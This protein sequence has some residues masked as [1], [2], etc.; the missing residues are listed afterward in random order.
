MGLGIGVTS[1]L[2]KGK[3]EAAVFK[4]IAKA[5]PGAVTDEVMKEVCAV[6]VGEEGVFA[7]LFPQCE[8]LEFVVHEGKLLASTKTSSCGP[9][10]HAEVVDVLNRIGK[11]CGLRWE[12]DGEHGGDETGFAASG[13]FDDLQGQMARDIQ[14]IAAHMS[15]DESH[16]NGDVP[17][18]ICWNMSAPTPL[19]PWFAICSSGSLSLEWLKAIATGPEPRKLSREYHVWWERV[20]TPGEWA[21][22]A[23]MLMWSEIRWHPPADEWEEKMMRL[24]VLAAGKADKDALRKAGVDD[25]DIIELQAMLAIG[26]DEEPVRP[27]LA[28]FGLFRGPARWRQAGP[29]S[30]DLPGYFYLEH[31]EE[32]GL[33]WW[34]TGIAVRMSVLELNTETPAREVIEGI[35]LEQGATK[36]I[37]ETH[38][39]VESGHGMFTG[40]DGYLVLAGVKV[41]GDECAIITITY[42]KPHEREAIAAWKS[43]TRPAPSA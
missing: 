14:M 32:G 20:R 23:T 29:W 18:C 21:K 16:G 28:G 22:L 30:V 5:I 15:R 8:P 4:A 10:Y 3:S 37:F 26:E 25:Q 41:V 1:A 33:N 9:G 42:E 27:R 12:W 7:Q 39:H 40:E 2:P 31:D 17:R 11:A 38:A 34:Y 35:V 13:D 43:I 24:A 6:H 19:G 36:V